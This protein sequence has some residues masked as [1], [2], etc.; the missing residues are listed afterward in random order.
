MIRT[1]VLATIGVFCAMT[2]APS[3]ASAQDGSSVSIEIRAVVQPFCRIQ[4]ELGESPRLLID[5]AVEL[6]AVRELCNTPG[7][8]NVNVQLINVS[9]GLLTYGSDSQTLDSGGR[10]RI[11]WG[12]PRSRTAPWRL[13][14]ASLLQSDMPVYLRVSISPI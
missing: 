7:G 10:T 14:Q 11:Q 6:G 12:M 9:S 4:S 8:Y 2:A 1:T 5:G 3:A 13:T